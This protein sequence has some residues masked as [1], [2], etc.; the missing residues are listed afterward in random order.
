MFEM[1]QQ[2]YPWMPMDQIIQLALFIW[3]GGTI[4][5]AIQVIDLIIMPL[6]GYGVGGG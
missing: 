3:S 5:V 4:W 1:L 6:M 2:L